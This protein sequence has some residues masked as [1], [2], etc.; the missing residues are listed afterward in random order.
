MDKRTDT[1]NATEMQSYVPYT[2]FERM[3]QLMTE[4][5]TTCKKK[6][7]EYGSSWCKRGGT[8]AYFTIIRKGDRLDAQLKK[9]GWNILDVSDDPMSTESLDETIKD[10]IAY[11][12][13]VLE[14]RE[15]IRK[16]RAERDAPKGPTPRDG[17]TLNDLIAKHKHQE[18]PATP[19]TPMYTYQQ[20]VVPNVIAPDHVGGT[21]VYQTNEQTTNTRKDP[22]ARHL[23]YGEFTQGRGVTWV[24]PAPYAEPPMVASPS[25]TVM[26]GPT[27]Y[28]PDQ[29]TG[30]GGGGTG[31]DGGTTTYS[32][33]T[34]PGSYKR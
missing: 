33:E 15:A 22:I 30:S 20:Q 7:A 34:V 19:F 5:V 28:T 13:L 17:E 3:A 10:Y 27:G 6:D 32:G 23:E 14:K 16:A 26:V 8:G 29:S 9:L 24:N 11:L 31:G 1:E 2:N 25:V 18:T 4:C 12:G 21:I